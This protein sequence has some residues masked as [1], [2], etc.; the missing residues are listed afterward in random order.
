M[1]IDA[2][3]LYLNRQ[4]WQFDPNHIYPTADDMIWFDKAQ[5]SIFSSLRM[6]T[7]LSRQQMT[8]NFDY[9][10][11]HH[12]MTA[13]L[14]WRL[15]EQSLEEDVLSFPNARFDWLYNERHPDLQ[16]TQDTSIVMDRPDIQCCIHV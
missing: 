9:G 5:D 11:L 7:P 12:P 16:V 4:N 8:L 2:E 10:A 3:T 1:I 15:I 6:I 13:D 14:Y